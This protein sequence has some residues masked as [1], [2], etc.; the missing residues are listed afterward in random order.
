MS[1]WKYVSEKYEYAFLYEIADGVYTDEDAENFY[2]ED[3]DGDYEF[4]DNGY[5]YAEVDDDGY[6][7]E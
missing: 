1:K 6:V 7:I 4:I 3:E 2:V 5:E